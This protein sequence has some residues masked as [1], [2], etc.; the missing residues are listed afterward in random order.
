MQPPG[1]TGGT[2]AFL[3]HHL[4]LTTQPDETKRREVFDDKATLERLLQHP[5][6]LF[7][8]PYGDLDAGVVAA[9]RDAGFHAAVT[10][11]PGVVSAGANRL[12]LPRFEMTRTDAVGLADRL[13]T[14]FKGHVPCES[15]R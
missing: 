1:I 14:I 6:R 4:A 8:Y 10:V 2:K 13:R 3:V 7:S 5:V 15:L 12:L 9:V 11:Q